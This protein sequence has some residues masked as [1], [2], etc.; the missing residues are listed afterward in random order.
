MSNRRPSA[1]TVI[2]IGLG[3]VFLANALTAIF[4]PN[5]FIEI[6]EGSSIGSILPFSAEVITKLIAVNDTL[7][8]AL[9]LFG[10]GRKWLYVWAGLW[11]LGVMAIIGKPVEILEETGLLAVALALFISDDNR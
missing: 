9:L 6:L 3:L 1:A 10:I 7:V 8:A 11:I 4:T 2:R 5:E